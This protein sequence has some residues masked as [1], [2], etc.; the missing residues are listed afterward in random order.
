MPQSATSSVAPSS[1]RSSVVHQECAS[2]CVEASC[3]MAKQEELKI[4]RNSNEIQFLAFRAF[5]PSCCSFSC[6]FIRSLPAVALL[7]VTISSSSSSSL[8]CC[9]QLIWSHSTLKTRLR[10]HC[11]QWLSH[12]CRPMP[13]WPIQLLRSL[14]LYV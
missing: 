12:G 7:I 13:M 14:L 8:L 5:F 10:P 2:V 9:D 1:C 11:R 6:Y 4:P 3:V